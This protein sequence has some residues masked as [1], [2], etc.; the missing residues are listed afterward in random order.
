MP[1]EPYAFS[2]GFGKPRRPEFEDC[3]FVVGEDGAAIT[4]TLR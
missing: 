3:K 2:G 4:L 1:K